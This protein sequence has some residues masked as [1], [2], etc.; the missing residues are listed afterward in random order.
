MKHTIKCAAPLL[1][2][3]LIAFS[4]ACVHA[5]EDHAVPATTSASATASVDKAAVP[6]ART[7]Q[8]AQGLLEPQGIL[9]LGD[10]SILVAEYGGGRVVKFNALGQ[11]VAVVAQGL[12]SPAMLA[13]AGKTVYLTE[14]KAN[15]VVRLNSNGTVSPVGGEIAE[16]LGLAIVD[17][18][19]VAVSHTQSKV[20]RWDGKA[21]QMLFSAPEDG[22]KRYGYRCLEAEPGGSILMSDEAEGQVLLLSPQGRLASWSKSF[23]S[24]SGIVIGPDGATYV[25]DEGNSGTFSRV[26]ASGEAAVL[27]RDLGKP[28]GIL[29]LDAKT[30]LVT[31]RSGSIWK[32]ELP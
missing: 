8:W 30:V 1:W 17:G 20:V 29:F 22:G 14:R 3:A 26:S 19:P 10:G 16:P 13:R 24:P 31:N 15:R 25:T 9:R 12:K 5:D 27:A 28:R 4:P 6:Q 11:K 18:R 7:S 23:E 2:A 32:L 21:W